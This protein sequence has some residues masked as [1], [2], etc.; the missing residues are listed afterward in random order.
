[1][2][3][4]AQVL[5]GDLPLLNDDDLRTLGVPMGPRK[6][7]LAAFATLD[8]GTPT[9]SARDDAAGAESDGGNAAECSEAGD[10]N[11]SAFALPL[12]TPAAASAAPP[13]PA[14]T[15]A[16]APETA[17]AHAADSGAGESATDMAASQAK[18]RRAHFRQRLVEFYA[19]IPKRRPQLHQTQP[20]ITEVEVEVILDVW[21]GREDELFVELERKYARTNN[22]N[23]GRAAANGDDGES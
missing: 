7:M 22:D 23:D 1:M 8:T 12:S 5:I 19:A 11:T 2:C 4:P 21:A 14:P 10:D 15:P 13:A 9:E 6:R 20:A 16:P 3:D 17:P 18:A